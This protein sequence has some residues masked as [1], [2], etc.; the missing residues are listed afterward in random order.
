V[1]GWDFMND[2]LWNFFDSRIFSGMGNFH[3]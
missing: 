2:L 3:E 1:A